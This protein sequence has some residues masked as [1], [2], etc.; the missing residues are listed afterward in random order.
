MK[1]TQREKQQA[2]RTLHH[3]LQMSQVRR[4]DQPRYPHLLWPLR[5]TIAHSKRM[6]PLLTKKRLVAG[7]SA[8]PHTHTHTGREASTPNFSLSRLSAW[9][10][11]AARIS[12]GKDSN[13]STGAAPRPSEAPSRQKYVVLLGRGCTH[14]FGASW[15]H[16]L[17][18]GCLFLRAPFF[19]GRQSKKHTCL[20][21]SCSGAFKSSG[22]KWGLYNALLEY[23]PPKD[24]QL[25]SWISPNPSFGHLPALRS[26]QNLPT[27][28]ADFPPPFLPPDGLHDEECGDRQL[29]LLQVC[30]VRNILHG[31]CKE[32]S[33][34]TFPARKQAWASNPCEGC[35]V[36]SMPMPR[37]NPGYSCADLHQPSSNKYNSMAIHIYIAFLGL[38]RA[39]YRKQP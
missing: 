32:V 35:R 24:L 16:F 4:G 7:S 38:H 23:M 27:T 29:K 28:K 5:W 34:Q 15:I 18:W 20:C 12:G 14:C 19:A 8:T 36:R 13:S 21:V 26:S 17:E 10:S 11:R 22:W 39:P 2:K 31:P 30:H 9:R 33:K 6:V 1:H 25:T 37:Q 3:Q